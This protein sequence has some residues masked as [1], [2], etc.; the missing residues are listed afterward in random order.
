MAKDII[1]TEPIKNG[2]WNIGFSDEQ[3]I[4]DVL[5]SAPGHFK[6]APLIGVNMNDYINSSLSPATVSELEKKILLNLESDGASKVRVK[7]DSTTQKIHVNG[8]Y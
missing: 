2:D 7:I 5:M 1:K 8:K 6:N 3:H 4:Q